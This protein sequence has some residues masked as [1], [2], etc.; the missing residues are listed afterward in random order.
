M[1]GGRASP[2]ERHASRARGRARS[3]QRQRQRVNAWTTAEDDVIRARYP[4]GGVEACL[5]ALYPRTAHA[6]EGRAHRLGARRD[7]RLTLIDHRPLTDALGAA[8]VPQ[9]SGARLVKRLA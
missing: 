3:A 2:A 9:I 1:N 5:G 6:I 4:A 7:P 8:R